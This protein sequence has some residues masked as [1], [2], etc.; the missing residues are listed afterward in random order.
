ML[1]AYGRFHSLHQVKD[2]F[3]NQHKVFNT[4]I[5]VDLEMNYN[6]QFHLTKH[7]KYKLQVLLALTQFHSL[8]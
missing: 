8:Y 6:A 7:C 3:C 4:S 5:S 1:N 2:H